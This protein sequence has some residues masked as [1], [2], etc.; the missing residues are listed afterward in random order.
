[1]SAPRYDSKGDFNSAFAA[2]HRDHGPGKV[3]SYGGKEYST[4]RADETD[5]SRWAIGNFI[6]NVRAPRESA[7]AAHDLLPT[8]KTFEKGA[9]ADNTEVPQVFADP[10]APQEHEEKMERL[11]Q[12]QLRQEQLGPARAAA[13]VSGLNAAGMQNKVE[14]MKV[15]WV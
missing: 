12:A 9:A 1:M 8:F 2:A 5:V 14:G 15:L 10:V 3:F 7:Q 11:K 4:T 13:P 6:E